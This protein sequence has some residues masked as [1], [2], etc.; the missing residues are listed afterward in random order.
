MVIRREDLGREGPWGWLIWPVQRTGNTLRQ[1]K[2]REKLV[3]QCGVHRAVDCM[4]RREG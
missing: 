1:G 3:Q 2:G 4:G